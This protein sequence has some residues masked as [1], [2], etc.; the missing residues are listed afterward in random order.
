MRHTVDGATPLWVEHL[1]RILASAT[2]LATKRAR[3]C[4][5]RRAAEGCPSGG[6]FFIAEMS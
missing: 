2:W 4:G 1:L 6:F 3:S 5:E